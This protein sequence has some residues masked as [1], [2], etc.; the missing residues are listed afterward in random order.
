MSLGNILTLLSMA[1]ALVA[2]GLALSADQ[3]RVRAR[4]DNL[5]QRNQET[6]QEL[7]TTAQ[8]IK[9]DVKEVKQ[10]VD[11]ILRKLDAMEAV[12]KAEQRDR[13]Q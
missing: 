13:R 11:L 1:G 3:E 7:R 4:L 10:N 12:R 6:R 5:E 8:E 9:A 2:G